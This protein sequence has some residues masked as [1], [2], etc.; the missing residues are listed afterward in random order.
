[1][2]VVGLGIIAGTLANGLYQ[3]Q[4]GQWLM[5]ALGGVHLLLGVVML[6]S[7]HLNRALDRGRRHETVRTG[8]QLVRP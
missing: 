6:I 7:R 3:D 2:I 5:F 8:G 1:L 4:L